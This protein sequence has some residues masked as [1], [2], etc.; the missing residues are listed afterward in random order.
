[1]EKTLEIKRK[2]QRFVQN[3]DLDR[4]VEEYQKLLAAD[5]SDPY[6]HVTLGDLYFK[7][8]VMDEAGRRY[9]E[10]SEAYRQAGL[11]K[12]A[13]AVC[14]K[15]LRLNLRNLDTLKSLAELHAHD[16][17]ATDAAQFYGQ[18]ADLMLAK[19]HRVQA[20]EALE[21]AVVLLPDDPRYAEKLGDVW[22]L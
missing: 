3:G 18:Y 13:I 15:M 5:D 21:A 16:G 14:K 22:L 17:L 20:A 11:V 19:E 9:Q 8:G 2:A 12:N 4:A 7:K 1:L 6:T 10:A